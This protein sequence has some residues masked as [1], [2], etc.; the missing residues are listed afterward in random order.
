MS[1]CARCKYGD[2]ITKPIINPTKQGYVFASWSG[3]GEG[4]TMG[5]T[6]QNFTATWNPATDTNYTVRH[7][8]EDLS[9]G[10]T[11]VENE[12]EQGTTETQTAA[13]PKTYEGFTADTSYAQVVIEPDGTAAV[14]IRYNR[15]SYSITWIANGV[16]YETTQNV[17][18]GEAISLPVGSPDNKI[19][20]TFDAWVGVPNTMPARDSSFEASWIANSYTVTFSVNGGE[21]LDVS[22]KE[23]TYDSTYGE[24]PIPTYA[25]YQFV[26]WTDGSGATVTAS[27]TVRTANDHVL[28]ANWAADTD[29]TYTVLHNQQDV[30]GG[31]YTLRDS[32]T[33]FGET[34]TNTTAVANSYSGF[35]VQVFNQENIAGDGSTVVNIYYDRN[36][37]TV[38]WHIDSTISTADYRYGAS[39]ST[40]NAT[41][42]GYNFTGW[43][44]A[45]AST[46]PDNDL[47]YTA[48]WIAKQY[49]VSFDGTGGSN[50]SSITVTYDN[51][52]G[53]LPTSIRTG[54]DFDGWFTTSSGGTKVVEST[55]V[56]ITSNQILYAH[57]TAKAYTVSFDLNTGIGT[58]PE[59][60]T[61]TYD[62]NY[63][64]LPENS[65]S[66]TGYTFTGWY[67]AASGGSKITSATRVTTANHHTLY[68]QWQANTYEVAFDANGG[69]GIMTNQSHTYD[70]SNSLTANGFTRTGYSFSGWKTQTDGSGIVYAN[71]ASVTNLIAEGVITLYAQWTVNQYSI[72]FDSNGGSGVTTI[73]QDYGTAVTAPAVPTK[74][75]YTFGA[76]Q[77]NSVDYTFSTMPAENI[78]LTARWTTVDYA[79]TYV[80]DGG[81]NHTGNPSSYNI[82]SGNITL[83]DASGKTGYTF[84]DW[85][86][87]AEFTNKVPAIAISAGETG[88][89]TFYAKWIANTYTII[90]DKNTGDGT[91]SIGQGFI[92]DEP[93]KAL[94]A[95]TFIRDGYTFDGWSTNSDGTGTSYTNMQMV[96]NLVQSGTVSLY[97]KWKLVTYAITY[98]LNGG[99]QASVNPSSYTVESN[100]M[101]LND[102]NRDSGYGFIGWYDNASLTGTK[103]TS[104]TKGSTG[105]KVLYAKWGFAGSFTVTN[106]GNNIFTIT[107]NGNGTSDAQN[108]GQQTVYFRTVNGSAIGGTHFS[109]QGGTTAAVTFTDGETTKTVTIT[110]YGV[111]TAYNGNIATSYSNIDRTF[112]LE[113]VSVVGGGLL[114]STIKAT[115]TM[116][117]NINYA[118][119]IGTYDYKVF[120]THT[121]NTEIKESIEGWDGTQYTGLSGNPFT[122]RSDSANVSTYLQ[123]TS[124][125]MRVKLDIT[126]QDSGWRMIRHVFFNNH[127]N[128]TPTG[129]SDG[130][131]SELPA[132]TKSAVV[133]ALTSTADNTITYTVGLPATGDITSSGGHA[134]SAASSEGI[135]VNEYILYSFVETS[136]I[137]VAAYNSAT[138]DSS[139]WYKGGTLYSAPHD[140]KEPSKIGIGPMASGDYQ[141]GETV[142]ISVVFDEIVTNVN[143]ATVSGTNLNAMTYSGGVGS[144]VLY[145]TGTVKTNSTETTILN[146]VTLSGTVLDMAN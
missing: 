15:N 46:M 50:P 137:S 112:Q 51:T 13:S 17:M 35:T 66:K 33:L 45:V 98:Q 134:V 132:G 21:A 11:I 106:N 110:E 86:T 52:Y 38:T 40:P 78:T 141:A 20:Y 92:Y 32:T 10:Y 72:S 83:G 79:I 77:Y 64:A 126:G 70:Q 56:Q 144:N 122:G 118:V 124:I 61:V 121:V 119:P 67:T 31:G 39:I 22:T 47:N 26:N 42:T 14:E 107:R 30:Q 128:G 12:L 71:S 123:K 135:N 80:L 90:F 117:K 93:A 36:V 59:A 88:A 101:A 111:A 60:I 24:L 16:T 143:G 9:G 125:S 82:E 131:L 94:T 41:R 133:Y 99:T 49:T 4:S 89:K 2:V 116:A 63:T 18:Y 54:Y 129:K 84:D 100:D 103:V 146:G 62:G 48:T 53:A 8:R 27:S 104:I 1:D 139:W 145:F 105:D 76:W 108:V 91:A 37:H 120:A 3:F 69:S 75:G 58:V 5:I 96:Q 74:T 109:H 114:G 127:T 7:I 97:A 68:A 115:R 85:Y 65:G 138:A 34:D 23:V 28:T 130:W 102:P 25:G 136:G 81:I 29:I 95:N 44:V 43:N 19:G 6:E 142:T 73:K 55:S 140:T 113:I 87:E 57:W